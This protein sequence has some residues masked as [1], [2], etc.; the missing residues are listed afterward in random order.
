MWGKPQLF[1]QKVSV[2]A[3]RVWGRRRTHPVNLFYLAQLPFEL[4]LALLHTVPLTPGE[5]GDSILFTSCHEILPG[6][7][8]PV[9][10]WGYGLRGWPWFLPGP[11]ESPK[12]RWARSFSEALQWLLQR[13]TPLLTAGICKLWGV[14]CLSGH[15]LPTILANYLV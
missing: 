11:E 7:T 5:E 9:A 6:V 12:P 15:F 2:V 14:F 1:L 4:S 3:G 13:G 8:E 10:W